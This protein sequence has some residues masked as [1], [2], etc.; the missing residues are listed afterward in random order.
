MFLRKNLSNDIEEE[1]ILM[2]CLRHEE[3]ETDFESTEGFWECMY[4]I[5]S[6]VSYTPH[7]NCHRADITENLVM[8][9]CC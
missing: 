8:V 1:E 7:T 9:T 3:S 6:S 5:E 4:I 2:L